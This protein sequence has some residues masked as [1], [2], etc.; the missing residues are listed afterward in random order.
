MANH[1]H[2]LTYER[3]PTHTHAH[4]AIESNLISQLFEQ[5][6]PQYYSVTHIRSKLPI[7]TYYSDVT[8]GDNS[9]SGR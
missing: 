2:S 4:T 6:S 3:P 7:F 5:R 9:D 8:L 1:R